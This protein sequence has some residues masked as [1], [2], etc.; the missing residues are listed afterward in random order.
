[1]ADFQII[2]DLAEKKKVTLRE[3]AA[4]IGIGEGAMQK[5]IKNG[6]TNTK[7]IEDIAKVLEVPV[8]VFFDDFNSSGNHSV[9][10]HGGAASIY[11]DANMK[12]L[13]NKDENREI[14]HLKMLLEEKEKAIR[15]KER[16]IQILMNK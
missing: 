12:V 4:R 2:R 9:T 7:T 11:G 1:M 10:N 16:T 8:G 3:I 13:K 5:L 6:S 15:D 14:T